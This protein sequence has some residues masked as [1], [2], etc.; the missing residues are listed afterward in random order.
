[1]NQ[2]Q[3]ACGMTRNK[4]TNLNPNINDLQETKTMF[5]LPGLSRNTTLSREN[6]KHPDRKIN[7][8]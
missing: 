4:C 6:D 2:T 8:K 5:R 7:K 1:M 3:K